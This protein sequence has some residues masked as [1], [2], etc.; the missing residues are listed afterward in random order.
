MQGTTLK[1]SRRSESRPTR[2]TGRRRFALLIVV[3][4]GALPMTQCLRQDEVECEEAVALLKECCPGFDAKII[5]CE[6][7]PGSCTTD[8]VYPTLST[9]DSEC[10]LGKSCDALNAD[11]TCQRVLDLNAR[12]EAERDNPDIAVTN[13]ADGGGGSA[14][15]R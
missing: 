5:N 15:C 13:E 12:D 1:V 9:A 4:I 10:M 2:P 3:V 14:I 8:A 7:S 11:K 6:F